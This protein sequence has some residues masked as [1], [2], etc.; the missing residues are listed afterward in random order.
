[1]LQ[2]AQLKSLESNLASL[3]TQINQRIQRVE[4]NLFNEVNPLQNQ[5]ALQNN[6]LDEMENRM[7]K[8]ARIRNGKELPVVLKHMNE[9]LGRI[10][11]QNQTQTTLIQ[12]VQ[13]QS[14]ELLQAYRDHRKEL[15]EEATSD[16]KE[17]PAP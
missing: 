12:Q 4:Q 1:T 9:V 11:P 5:V 13:T 2:R 17:P 16:S 8:E 3:Q 7:S 6:K 15:S 10:E 14:E